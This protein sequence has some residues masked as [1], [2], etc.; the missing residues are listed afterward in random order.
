MNKYPDYQCGYTPLTNLAALLA[1]HLLNSDQ[2]AVQTVLYSIATLPSSVIHVPV[3][4]FGQHHLLQVNLL[5]V[6]SS[7]LGHDKL[8]AFFLSVSPDFIH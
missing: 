6:T 1:T 7:I 3:I 2:I 5:L 8:L 4:H